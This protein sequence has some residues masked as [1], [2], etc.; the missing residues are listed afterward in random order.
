MK[1]DKWSQIADMNEE[2]LDPACT[3]YEGKIVVS[4]GTYLKS[5][6]A[7]DYYDNKW[8]HL[9]DMI[10]KRY[11][12]ASV[13]MGSK[14]FV[15]GGYSMSSCETLDSFS[16]KFSYIKTCASITDIFEWFY[17]V[18]ICN[19]IVIFGSDWYH[20]EMNM[21]IY[22]VDAAEWKAV[23]C[24]ILKNKSAASCLKFHQ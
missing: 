13:S 22:N 2:R 12:H 20:C 21:F 4:G 23:D 3:V 14:L 11:R 5:V 7:Y 6:E 1:C 9:P 19:Q 24:S 18:C 10:E 8:T 15:I 17:A 16:R